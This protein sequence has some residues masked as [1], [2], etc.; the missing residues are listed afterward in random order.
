MATVRAKLRCTSVTQHADMDARTFE[1]AAVYDSTIAE[2]RK[3]QQ[4][5]PSA[6]FKT[7][8]DNP[9]I[10]WKPGQYYYVDFTPIE[11]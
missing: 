7:L 5:S 9:A 2:D 11:A 4:Y 10:D 3:F 1:F 6:S 8:V